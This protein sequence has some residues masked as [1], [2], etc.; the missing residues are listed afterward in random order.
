MTEGEGP[1]GLHLLLQ[2]L[3]AKDPPSLEARKEFAEVIKEYREVRE[4]F[5]SDSDFQRESSDLSAATTNRVT[6]EALFESVKSMNAGQMLAATIR[7]KAWIEE[8]R[9]A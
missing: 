6:P 2:D 5:A 1:S 4:Q 3:Q 9:R 7:L 8:K